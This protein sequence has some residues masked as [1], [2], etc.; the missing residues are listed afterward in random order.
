MGIDSG[1]IGNI[2]APQGAAP[3][4]YA[5]FLIRF[6]AYFIDAIIIGIPVGIVF[7][8][9]FSVVAFSSIA[10]SGYNSYYGSGYNTGMGLANCAICLLYP[11][12]FLVVWGYFSW[13]ESSQYQATP[14]KMIL[15][16]KVTDLEGNRISFQ[17]AAIRFI[18]KVIINMVIYIGSLYII[19]SDKKQGIYDVLAGTLVVKKK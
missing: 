12:I 11:V 18:A 1:N 14:G 8:I 5:G 16:L 13:F 9:L 4:E 2:N 7:A 10:S 19:V 15:G 6:V 3:G 17:K